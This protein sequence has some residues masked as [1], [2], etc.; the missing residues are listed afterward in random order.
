MGVW[1]YSSAILDLGTRWKRVIS[2]TDYENCL[3]ESE[4]V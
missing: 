2:F 4:D 3:L 1:R